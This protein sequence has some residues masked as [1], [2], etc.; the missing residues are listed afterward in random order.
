MA[1]ASMN[2]CVGSIADVHNLTSNKAGVLLFP[3]LAY[4]PAVHQEMLFGLSRRLPAN[5]YSILRMRACNRQFRKAGFI[6]QRAPEAV[7][8]Q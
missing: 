4:L 5:L 6:V 1:R 3:L 2:G 8:G 7:Q